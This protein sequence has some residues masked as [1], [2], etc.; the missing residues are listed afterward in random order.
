[1]RRSA[2]PHDHGDTAGASGPGSGV[3]WRMGS[4]SLR[5]CLRQDWWALLIGS[6]AVFVMAG[7][8]TSGKS[9]MFVPELSF[10]YVYT[11]DGL[12]HAWLSQR[13][14][15]GWIFE[16]PR[17]GYP[18]GSAFFD[19]PGSDSGNLLI[20]KALGWC[21]GTWYG[22]MNLYYLLSY[23]AVFLAAYL[24]ARLLGLRQALSLALAV[25]YAM[26]TYHAQRLGH[27][28]LTWYFV[29]PIFFYAAVVASAAGDEG[30]RWRWRAGPGWPLLAVLV[31][32][33]SFGVYYAFFGV[34]LLAVGGIAGWVQT[35]RAAPLVRA[36]LYCAAVA[37]GVF[38]NVAP[39]IWYHLL[40][41]PNPEVA[42]R[43]AAES[44]Y[45][46]FKMM[47]LL[48]PRENHRLFFFNYYN[49]AY[50]ITRPLINENTS[51]TLGLVGAAGFLLSLW[52]LLVIAAGGALERRLRLMSVFGLVLFLFGTV[53]GLG[54]MFSAFVSPMLRSWNRISIFM[55]FGALF[56]LLLVLQ[57]ACERWLSPL[58]ARLVM[59]LL[60]VLLL[61][62]GLWDQ[63]LPSFAG[64][65]NATAQAFRQEQAFIQSIEAQLPPGSAVYQL[66]YMP[67]PEQPS[68]ERLE[69]YDLA[70]GYL[71][72]STLRWSYAGIRG[73]EG[74]LFYRALAREPLPRQLE[75]LQRL[76]FAG[77]YVDRR[78]Y[79]D[80]AT[81]L[82]TSLEDLTGAP[83]AVVRADGE[84]VFFRLPNATQPLP[85]GLPAA[86]IFARAGVAPPPQ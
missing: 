44:E 1:M 80:N 33:A 35:G 73:R 57:L 12:S 18:F 2:T 14:M 31:A 30:R 75:V 76:G 62:V 38:L 61:R 9:A 4:E 23:P 22:A 49:K 26:A 79:A 47:Q 43:H 5:A 84:V 41:G 71:H 68:L 21:T 37:G 17:S 10:P 28:F 53:G 65:I 55:A 85:D 52:H 40:H 7:M 16:N 63:T 72:S 32:A 29:A 83:P 48:L 67:F 42:A 74:D 15:E 58:R 19:Y 78:G 66:P 86:E 81:A 3:P 6:L 46:G 34:I 56:T 70:A 45:L 36:G 25:L 13:A 77:V 54:A 20:I 50:N 24:V 82:V 69:T 39:S 11:G 64:Q 27:I 59:A 51:A 60:A 8:F